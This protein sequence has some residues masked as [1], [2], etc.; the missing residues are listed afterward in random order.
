VV[1]EPPPGTLGH[2]LVTVAAQDGWQMIAL[3]AEPTTITEEPRS[4]R[5]VPPAVGTSV[6]VHCF[7][8]LPPIYDEHARTRMAGQ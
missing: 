4:G 6:E 1:G 5:G 7:S 8:S 3:A 2:R